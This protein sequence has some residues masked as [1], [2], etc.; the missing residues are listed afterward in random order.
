M[1]H[2]ADNTEKEQKKKNNEKNKDLWL[3]NVKD[4]TVKEEKEGFFFI[5]KK[6]QVTSKFN[7]IFPQH[8]VFKTC[9]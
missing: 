7:T 6:G 1:K 2:T 8:F 5:I 4:F 3:C 9:C